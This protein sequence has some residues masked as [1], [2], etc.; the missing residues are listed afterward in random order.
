MEKKGISLAEIQEVPRES[1]ILL[2]GSPGAGKSTFCHQA[3]LNSLAM[4]KPVIYVTT[5][6]G[7]S[8]VI[9]LMRERGVGT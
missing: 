1:L 9:E 7:P 5:E 3:V 8:E 6:H 2:S 4:D